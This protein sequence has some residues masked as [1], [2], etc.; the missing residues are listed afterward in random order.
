MDWNVA[1]AGAV[2]HRPVLVVD[3]Q[4]R[5]TVKDGDI[6]AAKLAGLAAAHAVIG[7]QPN[8]PREV[9][10]F[11]FQGVED[12]FHVLFSEALASSGEGTQEGRTLTPL[13]GF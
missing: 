8:D 2:F 6:G 12:D 11:E 9:I 4:H 3:T 1:N 7:E 13:N 10:G 5:D